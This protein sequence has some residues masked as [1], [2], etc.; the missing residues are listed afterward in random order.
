MYSNSKKEIFK[1][2]HEIKMKYMIKE[3]NNNEKKIFD[4]INQKNCIGKL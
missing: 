4:F 1:A 2:M 3:N